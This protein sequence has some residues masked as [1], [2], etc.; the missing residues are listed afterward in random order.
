MSRHSG[1]L[2]KDYFAMTILVYFFFLFDYMCGKN[3]HSQDVVG[4]SI[5][6]I[7]LTVI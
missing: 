1:E 3:M 7:N 5:K 6:I 2:K 4:R